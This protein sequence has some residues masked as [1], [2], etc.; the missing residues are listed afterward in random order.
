[1]K[2]A[3]RELSTA[4]CFDIAWRVLT[5]APLRE[6]LDGPTCIARVACSNQWHCI[7]LPPH[8]GAVLAT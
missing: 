6:R 8:R 2:I 4:L 7:K 1:M 3:M 5:L